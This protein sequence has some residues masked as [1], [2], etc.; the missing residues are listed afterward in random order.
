M[1]E[2][3]Q[4]DSKTAAS[5]HSWQQVSGGVDGAMK[6]LPDNGA[7]INQ[8]IASTSPRL[9]YQI[10]FP[11][12]G[13]Y[14]I[15]IRGKAVAGNV[16]TSD[17]LHVG[18][19][20]VVQSSADNFTGF[21]PDFDWQSQSMDDP[22]T[23]PYISVPSAGVHTV[24]LFMRED[25][26]T[27]DRFFITLAGISPG[28]PGHTYPFGPGPRASERLNTN[29][30]PLSPQFVGS[31]NNPSPTAGPAEMLFLQ[32]N[33]V[34]AQSIVPLPDG[35]FY[36][37]EFSD[38][39][40]NSVTRHLSDGSLDPTLGPWQD[41]G[42]LRL[43]GDSPLVTGRIFPQP[44]QGVAGSVPGG[45]LVWVAGSS[46]APN[47]IYRYNLELEQD[48]SYGGGDGFIETAE[49]FAISHNGGV[50][51][52][53]HL[54]PETVR[55]TRYSPN[56]IV[57]FQYDRPAPHVGAVAPDGFA[58]QSSSELETLADGSVLVVLHGSQ[59]EFR[60]LRKF[61]ADFTPNTTW[62]GDGVADLPVYE[63][64]ARFG[65]IEASPDGRI[66]VF[67]SD[68]DEV[69]LTNFNG[70]SIMTLLSSAGA[71]TGRAVYYASD[72]YNLG[73]A[74]NQSVRFHADGD[75]SVA[76]T[77]SGDQSEFV[78]NWQE[79][80][81]VS[82]FNSNGTLDSSFTNFDLDVGAFGD[83]T[84]RG[85]DT[86]LLADGTF[87]IAAN[88]GS[89]ALL[90]RVKPG[91]MLAPYKEVGG[92]V[93]LEA[94][95]YTGKAPGTGSAANHTWDFIVSPFQ[96][97][98]PGLRA[99]PNTGLNVGDSKSGP[100]RDYAINFT[101]T[102][103]YYVWV[104]MRGATGNDDSLHVGLDGTLRSFG[105]QGVALA[106]NERGNG[107]WYWKERTAAG[108]RVTVNVTTPGLHTLN[109]WMRED[110][111]EVDRFIL[112]RDPAFNPANIFQESGGRVDMEAERSTSQ[113]AGTGNAAGHTWSLIS[114]GGA[115]SG[116]GLQ[117]TPNTGLNVG[118]G[119][120][121]PRR[122][123]RIRFTTSG[124]YYGWVRMAGAN[125]SDDSLQVGMGGISATFGGQGVTL[126]ASE[127]GAG[128]F[129]KQVRS[130]EGRV[131]FGVLAGMT[132]NFNLWM[133]EDGTKVDKFI[134][135]IDPDFVPS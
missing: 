90:W 15:F 127:R 45:F 106:A 95:V 118:T 2:A 104:R 116:F 132:A 36:L 125:G 24:N 54:T 76:Y 67:E 52:F 25:G 57:E 13:N 37:F 119:L 77:I 115:S 96:N 88:A 68:I 10:N 58:Y 64:G 17:S 27:I 135:T 3:E 26:L 94:E 123:Y 70:E 65:G 60:G 50:V 21:G 22:N 38:A 80:F 40:G 93:E 120:N 111:V 7:N 20:G 18:L 73:L 113:A 16:G 103:T 59:T 74:G 107:D 100:R 84:F 6:A 81:G 130:P 33:D 89:D 133:R 108:M 129:W 126:S 122:D 117:A 131:G 63:P 91:P 14:D 29:L 30:R 110:G 92:F 109:L 128:W 75:V 19:D 53:R 42:V 112:T 28:A 78:E 87:L 79:G 49:E 43:D 85:V 1:V 11:Y 61:N 46:G 12:A 9:N 8:N 114:D 83:E 99:S 56:G 97:D 51:E 66:F 23:Q 41:E 62:A 86:A 44:D 71:V 134:L 31:L 34:S 5:G 4:F 48:G 121:G 39:A 55:W 69:S 98:L 32:G 35:R 82:R 101:T 105:S 47:R 102:G 124:T 72:Y